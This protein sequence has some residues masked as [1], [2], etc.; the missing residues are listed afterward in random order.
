MSSLLRTIDGDGHWLL[1]WCQRNHPPHLRRSATICH[2]SETLNVTIGQDVEHMIAALGTVDNARPRAKGR[3]DERVDRARVLETLAEA[4]KPVRHQQHPDRR[5]RESQR[6]RSA[7]L[8]R[9]S[10][11]V[12]VGGHARRHDRQGKRDRLPNG[13]ISSQGEP[14]CPSEARAPVVA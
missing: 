11:R 9:R 10:L 14:T 8:A 1:L 4:D 12:D 6:Y 7:D 5:D 13:E 2:R 3:A